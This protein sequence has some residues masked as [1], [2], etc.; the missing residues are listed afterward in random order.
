MYKNTYKKNNIWKKYLW[1]FVK[2]EI[3]HKKGYIVEKAIH[4]KTYT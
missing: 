1:S 4:K 2:R 3:M